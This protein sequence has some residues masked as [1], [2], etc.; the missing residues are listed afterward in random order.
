M[1]LLNGWMCLLS[2]VIQWQYLVFWVIE[3]ADE[4]VVSQACQLCLCNYFHC[5]RET[6][7]PHCRFE[8]STS[9]L[10]CRNLQCH[11]VGVVHTRSCQVRWWIG[12]AGQQVQIP[13]NCISSWAN[14]C[15]HQLHPKHIIAVSQCCTLTLVCW[16]A[17]AY[18]K[19][20]VCD[21]SEHQSTDIHLLPFLQSMGSS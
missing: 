12:T 10:V 4:P 1:E 5:Q 6:K 15:V 19:S 3:Q 17:K 20:K 14:N 7:V 2:I 21:K 11:W 8:V 13:A 16:A 9:F 18:S